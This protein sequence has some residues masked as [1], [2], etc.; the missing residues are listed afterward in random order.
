MG[1]RMKAALLVL[2]LTAICYGQE[3]EVTLSQNDA[4]LVSS[5]STTLS[6]L[7]QK[8]A[9]LLSSLEAIAENQFGKAAEA[10]KKDDAKAKTDGAAAPVELGESDVHYTKKDVENLWHQAKEIQDS[11]QELSFKFAPQVEELGESNAPREMP[12]SNE[13]RPRWMLRVSLLRNHGQ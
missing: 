2:A 9:D 3:Q 10:E 13:V 1:K 6:G 8:K 11:L 5:C 7:M 12:V 4:S